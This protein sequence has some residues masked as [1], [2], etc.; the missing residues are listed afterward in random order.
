VHA[1]SVSVVA[2]PPSYHAT[3]LPQLDTTDS[4]F[5]LTFTTPGALNDAQAVAGILGSGMG[6]LWT[7]EEGGTLLLPLFDTDDEE[8]VG[9][10]INSAGDVVGATLS[11]GGFT[12][13]P[14]IY[15]AGGI[16]T[17]LPT[18]GATFDGS[19]TDINDSGMI[20]G[21]S[22]NA[23]GGGTFGGPTSAVYWIDGDITEIGGL[24]GAT[25]YAAAVNES[26]VVTG[27]SNGQGALALKPFRWT[28]KGGFE[29]LPQL[30][31]GVPA[32][33]SDINDSN[34]VVGR[35]G[36]S[37]FANKAVYW[38]AQGAIHPLPS[39]VANPNDIGVL[40]VNNANV[41]V[42]FE[43]LNEFEARIWIDEEVF[44]LQEFVT[45]LPEGIE[46]Q[47]AIDINTNGD[48]VVEAGTV[49]DGQI[50]FVSVLLTPIAEG[51]D[52][53]INGDGVVD[54]ADLGLL[55]GAWDSADAAADL[56]GDGTVDG[57]DLGIL[58][59]AWS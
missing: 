54:G 42:G 41:M 40:A 49:V 15:T 39:I 48:I 51:G 32:T 55:L 17:E 46:L 47:R 21:E 7:P 16:F 53:D 57:A 4:E 38:D 52:P 30:V 27:A 33:P 56:N 28:Q 8:A 11:N 59:S 37:L 50:Q 58:L 23:P 24:G 5:K 18:L 26:G 45:D 20:V 22:E 19:A 12:A 34:V 43:L 25:S 44:H 1:I 9:A 29:V 2:T 13:H 36:L 3:V 10:G 31:N 6:F 35:G 14:F